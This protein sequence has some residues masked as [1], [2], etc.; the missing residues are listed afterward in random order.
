MCISCM[1]EKVRNNFVIDNE[2]DEKF[3]KKITRKLGYKKGNYS[4]ALEEAIE[5]WIKK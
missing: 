2:L 1:T 4:I 5:D 3:R